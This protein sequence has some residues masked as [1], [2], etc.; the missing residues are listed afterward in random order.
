MTQ[1]KKQVKAPE[2]ISLASLFKPLFK[3]E[4]SPKLDVQDPKDIAEDLEKQLE[5]NQVEGKQYSRF[6]KQREEAARQG[7]FT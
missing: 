1:Q 4:K 6:M 3:K 5:A 7:T 2:K